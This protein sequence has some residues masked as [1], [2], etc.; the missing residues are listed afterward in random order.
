[1]DHNIINYDSSV[2]RMV[3]L[4]AHRRPQLPFIPFVVIIFLYFVV[5]IQDDNR[6]ML[7][8]NRLRKITSGVNQ[9]IMQ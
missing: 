7:I 9:S 5:R 4:F 6:D 1:M 3:W 2:I 8:L